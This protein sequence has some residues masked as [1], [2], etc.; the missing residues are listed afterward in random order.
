MRH[1]VGIISEYN[2]FHNGH[3]YQIDKIREEMQ[4]AIIIAIMSGNVVQRGEF[5]MMDKYD[6]AKIALE[7]GVDGVFEIPYPYCGSTA[8]IFANAGVEIAFRLG[9]EYLYFGIENDNLE[10]IEKI[11]EIIDSNEFEAGMK[12]CIL[13][14][15]ESYI[16]AKSL[17]LKKF[18]Y[19]LPSKSNNILAVEYIRAIKNKKIDLK[20]RA[21]KR[22]GADYNSL[23][24]CQIMSASAIRKSFYEN[25]Q[26]L[27]VP[28]NIKDI[29]RDVVNKKRILDIKITSKLYH[30]FSLMNYQKIAECFDSNKEIGALVE[31]KAN[32]C[33]N[34]QEFL[35]LL[36][37]KSFTNSRVK[38]AILY[39][40]FQIESVDFAPK[41]TF[42]LGANEGARKIVNFARKNNDFIIITKHA[43]I[44]KLSDESKKI[45]EKRYVVDSLYNTLLLSPKAPSDAYKNRPIIK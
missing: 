29:Y 34:S 45:A 4:D 36:T 26:I 11:A 42:M 43:D 17:T 19:E 25:N 16:S 18:G 22:V 30:T 39:A 2:P 21:I 35:D 13:N 23:E 5:A 32:G 28:E 41:F 24:I 10:P 12:D 37:S 40:M 27:S 8:E 31:K 44:E 6:R 14:K 3:K 9:C 20:Y 7:C 1:V 15:K 38:R 33:A